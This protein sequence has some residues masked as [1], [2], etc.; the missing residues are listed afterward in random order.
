MTDRK[1]LN[2]IEDILVDGVTV[3]TRNG[4]VRKKFQITNTFDSTP[5][6]SIRR[7]AW[8]KALREMEFFLAGHY[9]INE[10]HPSVHSWWRPWAD[11]HG[12]MYNS[13]G[14]Q[15]RHYCGFDN[16]NFDQIEYLIN[17]LKDNPQSRRQVIT[18]WNTADMAATRTLLTSCHGT[19][20]QTDVNPETN[21]LSLFMYQRSC[22]V[23][24]GLSHNMIQYWAFL[25]YLC[26]QTGHKP[27]K[28]IHTLGNAHIYGPHLDM[29]HRLMHTA[30]RDDN[31]PQLV[32]TPSSEDFKADDFSLDRD[33]K[34]VIKETLPLIV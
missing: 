25:L 31:T 3:E 18:T 28:F 4:P 12:Q 26:H 17:E 1:Y 20:I 6:V 22:D 10:L 13:Y 24:L 23:M 5:L 15:F 2:I 30:I 16:R 9:N 33:Y 14:A 21:E 19:T 34:P 32:Y 29:A 8:K 11:E 27:G 7:T